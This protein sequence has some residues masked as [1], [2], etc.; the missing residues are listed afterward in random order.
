MGKAACGCALAAAGLL[1]L[2][3]VEARAGVADL[4]ELPIEQLLQI[5]VESASKYR[6]QA[7]DAPAAVSVVGAEDIRSFG[8]RTLAEVIGSI[9]GIHLSYDRYFSYVGVRGFA[10]AGDY[11]SRILLLVD[12][13]RQNDSVFNQAMLGT[14]SPIDVDLIERV[15]FVPGAGSSV[16]GANAF[17]GVINVVTKRGGDYRDGEAAVAVGSYGTG[18]VRLTQGGGGDGAAEWLLSASGYRQRGQDLRFPERGGRADDL[19]GDR[20]GSVFA[21]LSTPELTL[22]LSAGRRSKENPTASFGQLFNA[23]G[24][25]SVDES[26]MLSAAYNKTL[27]PMLALT[28]RAYAQQYRYRGDFVYDAPPRYINRDEA[29]GRMWGGELQFTSTHFRN[30]RLV[31]GA[32]FRRDDRV[33]QRNF[34]VAPYVSWLDSRRDERSYGVFVQD[35]IAFGERFLVNLG[36]RHDHLGDAPGKT[37]PRLGLI[38]RPL[39]Q[40]AVKLIYGEAFRPPNAFERDYE[41]AAPGGYRSNPALRPETLRSRELVL[42]HAL[43]PAQRIVASVFRNDVD[44]L[45]VQQYDAGADRF[46][47]ANVAS[48]RATGSELEWSGRFAGGIAVRVGASWQRAEDRTSGARLSNS[49]ARLFKANLSAPFWGERL[50]AG[51][52]VQASSA[53]KAEL[54]GEAPGFALV[55]LTVLAPRLAKNLEVS[56]S[57]YNLFD[58]RYYDPAGS[59]LAPIERVAQNGRNVRLKLIYRF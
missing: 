56:A 2:A 53:R 5:E 15:E 32:E 59:E 1:S 21:K 45:I 26:A 37:S 24:A 28:A 34:D 57:L 49:P 7:L 14:E 44:D 46:F 51:L 16:Y 41:T 42:E 54:G 55:N 33:R 36:L 12:G 35:E 58:R 20:S 29:E 13:V 25:S 3:A 11:N 22:G 43:S 27:S 6:Q 40:T 39:P 19:D 38:F 23:P 50:R 48:V 4:A 47:F 17:F 52:E 18:Q 31:F 9:R 10:R 8:Y 30:Q